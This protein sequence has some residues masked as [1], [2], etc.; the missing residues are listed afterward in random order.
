MLIVYSQKL[1]TIYFF[2]FIVQNLELTL[3]QESSTKKFERSTGTFATSACT[4]P[5]ATTTIRRI[6]DRARGTSGRRLRLRW[7]T[8]R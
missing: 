6:G 4:I 3:T 1:L 5:T 7:N 8:Q 2:N